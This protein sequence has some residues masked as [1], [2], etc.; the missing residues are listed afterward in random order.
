MTGNRKQLVQHDP[1]GDTTKDRVTTQTFPAAGT[2]N[3]GGGNGGPHAL[4]STSTS[5]STST[6]VGTS[7]TVSGSNRFDAVGNTTNMYTSKTGT[8]A[9]S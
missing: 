2:L 3:T 7:T 9:L 8:T 6:K 5:T 1:A 4:T